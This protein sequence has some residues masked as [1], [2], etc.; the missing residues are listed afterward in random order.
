MTVGDLM[1][2]AFSDSTVLAVEKEVEQH[3]HFTGMT[4]VAPVPPL[5]WKSATWWAGNIRCRRPILFAQFGNGVVVSQVDG[6]SNRDRRYG[7]VYPFHGQCARKGAA[8][9][10]LDRIP[11]L[12]TQVGSPTMQ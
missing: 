3:R 12:S 4:L 7:L 2:F 6:V 1:R 8:P 5:I 10:V 11:S 9:A